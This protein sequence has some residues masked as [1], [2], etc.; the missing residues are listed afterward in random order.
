AG[1]KKGHIP[2]Y[3]LIPVPK[4]VRGKMSA[5]HKGKRI[6][7]ATEFTSE[8]VK[9]WW[10]DPKYREAV[11]KAISAKAKRNWQNPE[12]VKKMMIA[13]TCLGTGISL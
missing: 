2:I 7:P 13:F 10:Q 5:S 6:S 9:S 11:S 8:R 3:K 12:F 4:H 1:F